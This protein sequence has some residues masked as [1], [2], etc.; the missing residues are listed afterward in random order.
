[1]IRASSHLVAS[2]YLV[3]REGLQ[4]GRAERGGRVTW[5]EIKK[6]QKNYWSLLERIPGR[7]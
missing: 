2:D 6:P 7:S 5:R 1:M 3:S 4:A